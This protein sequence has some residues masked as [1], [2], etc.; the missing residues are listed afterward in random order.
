[1]PFTNEIVERAWRRSGSYCE[2][3]RTKHGHGGRCNKPL[4]R[5]LRGAR[6]SPFGWEAYSVSGLYKNIASDCEILCWD[7]YKSTI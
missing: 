3:T 6:D 7:C 4:T 1:M 5:D 2:C